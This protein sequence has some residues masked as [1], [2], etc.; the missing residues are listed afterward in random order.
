MLMDKVTLDDITVGLKASDWEDAIRKSSERLLS[1]GAIEQGYVDGMVQS[2]KD[3]GPYIVI[4][5][6]VALAHTR[7]EYGV[8][9]MAMSFAL[10]DTPIPFGSE[11]FDPVKLII[12]FAAVDNESHLDLLSELTDILIDEE[13]MAMLFSAK[14]KEEFYKVLME[15]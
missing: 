10:L 11:T 14:T 5:Q 6:H 4:A 12:T 8:N 9:E 2:L 13:R 15:E 7:P 3:N 1:R